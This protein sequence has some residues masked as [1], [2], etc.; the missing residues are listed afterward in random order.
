[1]CGYG[2]GVY[3]VDI[4]LAIFLAVMPCIYIYTHCVYISVGIHCRKQQHKEQ[5]G[6]P[7]T[8]TLERIPSKSMLQVSIGHA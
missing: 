4:D 7:P 5:G 3:T 1:M 6:A 2:G 8:I